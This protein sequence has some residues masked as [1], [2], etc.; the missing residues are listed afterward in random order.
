MAMYVHKAIKYNEWSGGR[1]AEHMAD[2]H[3]RDHSYWTVYDFDIKLE[4][5]LILFAFHLLFKKMLSK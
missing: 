3:V 1:S 5:I 2:L 4:I